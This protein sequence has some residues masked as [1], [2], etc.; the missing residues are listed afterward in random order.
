MRFSGDG[1]NVFTGGDKGKIY[2]FDIESGE[3]VAD[4]RQGDGF[5]SSIA[6]SGMGDLAFGNS[7]GDVYFKKMEEGASEIVTCITEHKR[8][9]R[10][11]EF[12]P[13]GSKLFLASDDLQ[14]SIFDL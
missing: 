1:L 12:S 10:A 7:E 14:I 2:Q 6:S 9:I 5:I 13:D 8:G 3:P 4:F 11:I